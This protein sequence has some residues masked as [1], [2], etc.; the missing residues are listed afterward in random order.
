MYC[1]KCGQKTDGALTLC[2][3][4]LEKK[5]RLERFEA[6]N[7]DLPFELPHY[8]SDMSI[9]TENQ[10]QTK[11]GVAAGIVSLCLSAVSFLIMIAL[12]ISID[13]VESEAIIPLALLS[14]LLPP[15]AIVFGI[16]A[17][18][19]FRKRCACGQKKPILSLVFGIVGVSYS[20]ETLAVIPFLFM[21]LLIL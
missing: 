3:E 7:G 8:G 6:Y 21:M 19:A 18:R 14:F 2:A 13:F 20:A 5:E 12:L 15:V 4:C 10:A 16:V 17:I 1:N 9:S 11:S